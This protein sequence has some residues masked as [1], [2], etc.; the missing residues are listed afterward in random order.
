MIGHN[1]DPPIGIL[2]EIDNADLY[3]LHNRVLY[4]PSCKSMK[5]A[6]YAVERMKR[7]KR[8]DFTY[9]YPFNSQPSGEEGQMRTDERDVSIRG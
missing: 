3:L 1:S 9:L 8:I 7:L 5:H 2:N 6:P 4:V